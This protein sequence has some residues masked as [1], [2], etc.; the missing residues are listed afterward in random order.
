MTLFVPWLRNDP[1]LIVFSIV[2]VGFDFFR[3]RLQILPFILMYLVFQAPSLFFVNRTSLYYLYYPSIFFLLAIV[4][5]MREI[6][7]VVERKFLVSGFIKRTFVSISLAFVVFGLFGVGG[8]FMDDCF[9]IQTPWSNAKKASVY[10]VA[11]RIE[12]VGKERLEG[13]EGIPLKD[14]KE[15]DDVVNLVG[16]DILHLFVGNKEFSDLRYNYDKKTD[17]LYVR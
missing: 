10:K 2:V 8:K 5:L 7:G 6:Y 14:I 4:L 17:S 11:R 13:G 16:L 9:L 12:S 1:L 3:R 15:K